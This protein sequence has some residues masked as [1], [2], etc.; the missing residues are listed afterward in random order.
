MTSRDLT[1]PKPYFRRVGE[2]LTINLGLCN[3]NSDS[4]NKK[5]RIRASKKG[6]TNKIR[7]WDTKEIRRTQAKKGFGTRKK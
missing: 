4:D 5:M 1:G 7:I 6:K 3:K 2:V